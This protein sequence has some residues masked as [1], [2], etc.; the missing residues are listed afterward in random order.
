MIK[1]LTDPKQT[2]EHF[3]QYLRRL[4]SSR[5]LCSELMEVCVCVCVC[6]A[7]TSA[8]LCTSVCLKRCFHTK[9]HFTGCL[10]E[11]TRVCVCVCVWL[12]WTSLA[13]LRGTNGPRYAMISCFLYQT[14]QRKCS[15]S[16]KVSL[17]Q[18]SLFIPLPDRASVA[19][20]LYASIGYVHK[21]SW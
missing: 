3:Q 6:V 15:N 17:Y 8:S 4:W 19:F 5:F 18:N 16:G 9:M 11:I 20:L 2:L 21:R 13:S 7:R 14:V 1:N 12:L 10:S